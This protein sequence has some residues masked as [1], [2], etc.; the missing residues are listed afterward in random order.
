MD[1]HGVAGQ[2]R[3]RLVGAS[4]LNAS[5]LSFKAGG[6]VRHLA[7]EAS[8]T[9]QDAL[10][11]EASLGEDLVLS[12]S[13]GDGGKVQGKG[14]TT[15]IL[16]DSVVRTAAAGS[17]LAALK[18]REAGGGGDV[19]LRNVTAIASG[20]GSTGV[21]CETTVG[22]STLVNV[23]VRGVARDIDAST[24]GARCDAS[25]SSFRPALSPGLPTGT[26]NQSQEPAFVDAAAGDFHPAAGS[27]TIDAGTTDPLLGPSDPDGRARA[28]GAA[29]D[30]GAFESDPPPT[31]LQPPTASMDSGPALATSPAL[32]GSTLTLLPSLGR[33]V[34]VSPAGGVVLIKRRGQAG[35]LPLTG[36]ADIP[37]GSTVDTRRGTVGLVSAADGRGA[38]QSMNFSAGVFS[39]RQSASGGGLTDIALAGSELSSCRR[40]G[41]ARSSSGPMARGA[42]RRATRRLW[43]DGHGRFRTRGRYGAATVRGTNWL[44]EDSCNGTLV[45]VRRGK[46]AVTDY[47]RRRTVTVKAG[48]SYFARAYR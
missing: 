1:L 42:R 7:I 27:P 22:R 9:L 47:H 8:A 43:G 18:L 24:T 34:V 41:R 13:G 28:S 46:V 26:A 5:T 16:R 21:R 15:T 30:I 45:R 37:V 3:P 31:G 12:A 20:S 11:L 38:T 10:T 48:R 17:G 36:P 39:V 33:S 35:F 25:Y 23:I 2:P 32:A 6:T 29:P 19:A 44:T 4:N 14:S 40:P